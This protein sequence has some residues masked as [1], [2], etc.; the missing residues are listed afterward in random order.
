MS[1]CEGSDN[2]H[3]H[4]RVSTNHCSFVNTVI[5]LVGLYYSILFVC[6]L[7]YR[8]CYSQETCFGWSIS[9]DQS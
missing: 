6:S 2:H 9:D 1:V 4:R 8:L 3:L 5:W 7:Q